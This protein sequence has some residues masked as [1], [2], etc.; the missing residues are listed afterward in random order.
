MHT[1][2]RKK[3]SLSGNKI[4]MVFEA[5]GLARVTKIGSLGLFKI[6]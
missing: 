2:L 6:D 5:H 4:S 1:K 3:E